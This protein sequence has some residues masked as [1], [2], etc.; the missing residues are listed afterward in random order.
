MY[1]Y[2]KKYIN[3]INEFIFNVFIYHEILNDV[4]DIILINVFIMML[5]NYLYMN[6]Y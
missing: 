6:R 3:D 5:M 2:I 1:L 4:N